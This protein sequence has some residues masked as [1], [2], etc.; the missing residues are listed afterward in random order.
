MGQGKT[1]H[2]AL[3]AADLAGLRDAFSAISVLSR[4]G[5]RVGGHGSSQ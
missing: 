3:A 1:G 5:V 2:E 4:G